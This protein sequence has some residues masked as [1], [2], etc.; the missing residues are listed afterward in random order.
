LLFVDLGWATVILALAA[1]PGF[2]SLPD[3]GDWIFRRYRGNLAEFELRFLLLVLVALGFLAE[4]VGLHAAI[5]GFA[6]GLVSSE[7]IQDHE[8]LAQKLKVVVFSLLA[9]VF[10]LRAGTQ[11][12]LRGVDG[13]TLALTLALL[14]GA[15]RFKYAGTAL[16]ARWFAPVLSTSA[17]VLLFTALS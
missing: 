9:P 3:V 4:R 8:A 11:L 1:A 6:A 7:M 15:V 2:R 17:G 5:I 10:F 12:D 13:R 14:A 16:A